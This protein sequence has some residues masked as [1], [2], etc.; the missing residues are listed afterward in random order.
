MTCEVR[1]ERAIEK[2]SSRKTYVGNGNS[3]A[4]VAKILEHVLNKDRSLSDRPLYSVLAVPVDPAWELHTDSKL[5]LVRAGEGDL[6][7][8]GDSVVNRI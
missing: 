5:D 1:S 4:R 8:H 7:G 3:F 6:V 2:R